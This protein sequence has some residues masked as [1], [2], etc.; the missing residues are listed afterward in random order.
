MKLDARVLSLQLSKLYETLF[1]E[2]RRLTLNAHDAGVDVTM[3]I[4]L[5]KAYLLRAFGMPL[6]GKI[7]FHFSLADCGAKGWELDV[8]K[9]LGLLEKATPA[10]ALRKANDDEIS[11]SGIDELLDDDEEIWEDFSDDEPLEDILDDESAG[12][13]FMRF[14]EKHTLDNSVDGSN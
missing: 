7:D 2:D 5:V 11:Q 1:P 13:L 8:R 4:R 12:D 6:P 10:I 9:L 3:T 14:E